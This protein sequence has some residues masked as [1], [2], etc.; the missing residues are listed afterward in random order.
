MSN[1]PPIAAKKKDIQEW[2]EGSGVSEEIAQL[3]LQ[4][5]EDPKE[6]AKLLNW[7]HYY[8]SPV[9]CVRSIDLETGQYRKYA[10]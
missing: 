6:I 4:T 5:L 10:G 3:N 2:V 1:C 8:G 7:S 9:W